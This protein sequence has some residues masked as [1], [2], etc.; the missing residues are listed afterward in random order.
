[1]V[2]RDMGYIIYYR[3][4]TKAEDGRHP[5]KY[6]TRPA[7]SRA[8]VVGL[9]WPSL[10]SPSSS[11]ARKAS[12]CSAIRSARNCPAE[13]SIASHCG[14]Q[15]C[16][17]SISISPNTASSYSRATAA[18][19]AGSGCRGLGNRW[20][21]RPR[22]SARGDTSRTGCPRAEGSGRPRR[23]FQLRITGSKCFLRKLD[24]RRKPR[25]RAGLGHPVERRIVQL[26]QKPEVSA[27]S[28]QAT[29][30]ASSSPIALSASCTI[31]ARSSPSSPSM[32]SPTG[33]PGY[34]S[35]CPSPPVL[36]THGAGRPYG[37]QGG[38]SPGLFNR[39]PG[40]FCPSRL[41]RSVAQP[42]QTLAMAPS[43]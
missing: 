24:T 34:P 18:P 33:P 29:T 5:T 27:Q 3:L 26:L 17:S 23:L 22:R 39:S 4:L 11:S 1:M 30:A 28:T 42:T 12:R 38:D 2:W 31:R 9:G 43:P 7:A 21:P 19:S 13:V 37:A 36:D 25:L 35:A 8:G 15:A 10:S 16:S 20:R 6:P 41:R 32:K 14:C 40:S